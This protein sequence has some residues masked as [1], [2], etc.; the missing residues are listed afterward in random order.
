M[1]DELEQRLDAARRMH[2][3][4]HKAK[5]ENDCDWCLFLTGYD[6]LKQALARQAEEMEGL[7]AYKATHEGEI[8]EHGTENCPYCRQEEEIA[9]LRT[10][11][12]AATARGDKLEFELDHVITKNNTPGGKDWCSSCHYKLSPEHAWTDA[13]WQAEAERQIS[14]T[15]P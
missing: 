2:A 14:A 4:P 9:R 8:R 12:V 6:A 1:K 3:L 5:D 10:E 13:Q 7:R 15:K 11:L